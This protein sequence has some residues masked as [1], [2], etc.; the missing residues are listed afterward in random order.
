MRWDDVGVGSLLA[1]GFGLWAISGAALAETTRVA[2][3]VAAVTASDAYRQGFLDGYR[4]RALSDRRQ[5][6]RPHPRWRDR[7]SARP[8]D[9]YGP[10]WRNRPRP[11]LPPDVYAERRFR[12]DGTHRGR[13][14]A[15]P[16]V[17]EAASNGEQ[18]LRPAE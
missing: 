2:S 12:P 5:V 13:T 3:P 11:W 10:Y 16:S 9:S 8:R 7:R 4:A 17:I 18:Q 14:L 1:A 6:D 15:K